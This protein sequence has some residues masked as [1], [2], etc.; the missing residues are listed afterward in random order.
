MINKPMFVISNHPLISCLILTIMML[1][2]DDVYFT[3]NHP[4][5]TM[6]TNHVFNLVVILFACVFSLNTIL[7]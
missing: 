6:V 3:R 7:W 5:N 1:Y 2:V 4:K